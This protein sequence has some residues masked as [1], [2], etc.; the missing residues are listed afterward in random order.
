MEKIDSTKAR[1]ITLAVTRYF[2]S[3][4]ISQK[5]VARRLG[6]GASTVGNMLSY[7]RFG[8]RVAARWA[9]EFGFNEAFL[10]TG[11]GNLIDR[12]SGYQKIVRENEML[13]A[14]VRT[15]KSMLAGRAR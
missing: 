10:M 2:K 4:G 14:I 13:H 5:E 11:R 1:E 8:K 12:Q 3:Q 15:Q 6:C 9:S 7:G